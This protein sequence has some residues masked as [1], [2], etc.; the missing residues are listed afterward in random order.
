MTLPEGRKAVGEKWVHAVE[1]NAEEGNFMVAQRNSQQWPNQ[2]LR[3]NILDLPPLFQG[4]YTRHNYSIVW[5]TESRVVQQSVGTTRVQSHWLIPE[6]MVAGITT[7]PTTE[8]E[9]ATLKKWFFGNEN[10]LEDEIKGT[11]GGLRSADLTPSL[12]YV[13]SL[14]LFMLNCTAELLL[15]SSS[16]TCSGMRRLLPPQVLFPKLWRH[17]IY[18]PQMQWSR[19]FLPSFLNM[20]E[21]EAT[22]QKRNT[23]PPHPHALQL[24]PF[25]GLFPNKWKVQTSVSRLQT[26]G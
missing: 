22:T 3:L 26:E 8:I 18:S 10:G 12:R 23:P 17:S 13:I 14:V 5:T 1:E 7:K 25:I 4:T 20:S 16:S 21:E 15:F 24:C 9:V 19:E 6:D 11:W 2:H